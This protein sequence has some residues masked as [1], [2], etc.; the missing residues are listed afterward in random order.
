[1]LVRL[2]NRNHRI[3]L[4][5]IAQIV[6]AGAMLAGLPLPLSA[7]ILYTG[8]NSANRTAPANGAPFE[9]VGS[10][11]L[12]APT[13]GGNGTAIHLRGKYFLTANHVGVSSR[14]VTFDGETYYKIDT[15]FTSVKIT[16]GTDTVDMKVCKL[17]EDPGLDDLVLNTNTTSD[18]SSS[19]TSVMV[20]YGKGRSTTLE[21]QTGTDRTWVW[22]TAATTAKRWGTNSVEGALSVANIED[23][24][25]NYDGLAI[26][27]NSGAGDNEAALANADSGSALFQYIGGQ[28]VLSG[29]ATLVSVDGS[30]TFGSTSGLGPFATFSGDSNYYVRI[31][32]YAA[33]IEAALPDLSTFSGWLTDNSLSGADADPTADPDADGMTNLEEFAYGTDPVSWDAQLGPQ[34][35]QVDGDLVLS[36]QES[37][38]AAGLSYS[39]EETDDLVNTPFAA[40]ALT[41]EQVGTGTG[42]TTWQ[43]TLTPGS[44]QVFLRL[45]VSSDG[46]L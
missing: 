10:V 18:R 7:L 34:V 39:V 29:L 35:T 19:T 27:V 6:A 36:W 33:Q 37:S 25:Y 22:G 5:K 43:V 38:T 14:S 32:S 9:Q 12:G 13:S 2:F 28:W 30:S 45:V 21:D 1:V 15:A 17:A 40:S 11:F 4:K 44:G 42:V 3:P 16:T 24:N 8:D 31:S 23:Y 20:G 26:N 46:A 41:P